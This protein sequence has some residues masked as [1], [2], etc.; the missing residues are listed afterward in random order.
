MELEDG[1][2]MKNKEQVKR[3][4][5]MA[6]QIKAAL[7]WAKKELAKC[8]KDG[9]SKSDVADHILAHVGR[10]WNIGAQRAVETKLKLYFTQPADELEPE[11]EDFDEE[12]EDL[13]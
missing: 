4:A 11:D 8:E 5:Y 2:T 1:L 6:K 9:L 7:A 10:T 13:E 12:G 3:D